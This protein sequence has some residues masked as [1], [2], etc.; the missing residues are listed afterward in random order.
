MDCLATDDEALMDI[1]DIHV[2]QRT[3]QVA[4]PESCHPF[5]DASSKL[6]LP[7]KRAGRL[8]F[9]RQNLADFGDQRLVSTTRTLA[10]FELLLLAA[11]PVAQKD[12]WLQVLCRVPVQWMGPPQYCCSQSTSSTRSFKQ[13]SDRASS[14]AASN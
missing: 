2:L 5:G 8:A 10:L 11:A 13:R 12:I 3:I 14:R 6:D 1:V 7:S 9:V 4:A